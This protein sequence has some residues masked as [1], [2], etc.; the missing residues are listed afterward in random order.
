MFSR[1]KPMTVGP[2]TAMCVLGDNII[3]AASW[4]S[5]VHVIHNPGRYS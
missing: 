3:G 5:D 2:P 4:E 1:I